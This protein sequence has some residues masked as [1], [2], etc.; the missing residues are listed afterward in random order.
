MN[1]ISCSSCDCSTDQFKTVIF[2]SWLQLLFDKIQ[3]Q[4]RDFGG[5]AKIWSDLSVLL[6][7]LVALVIHLSETLAAILSKFCPTYHVVVEICLGFSQDVRFYLND[8]NTE[9]ET[10]KLFFTTRN[11]VGARL[12][13]HRRV[14]FCS[15]GGVCLSACWDATPQEQT[16]P[17]TDTPWSRHP[18][19]QAIPRSRHPLS[20]RPGTPPGADPPGPGRPPPGTEHAGRH[21]QREGGTHPTGM[22][23]C[24]TLISFVKRYK[25]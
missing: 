13:F 1:K 10:K 12:C 23:S 7:D 14:W 16:P 4:D 20:P 21:G 8:C 17:G 2:S 5:P 15:Q 22:Q 6:I 9:I 25:M 24:S 3:T 18:L 11:E 19:D